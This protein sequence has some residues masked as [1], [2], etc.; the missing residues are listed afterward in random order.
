MSQ[1]DVWYHP[2]NKLISHWYHITLTLLPGWCQSDIMVMSLRYQIVDRVISERH[3]S[4]VTVMS[5]CWLRSTRCVMTAY[6]IKQKHP[7]KHKTLTIIYM[8]VEHVEC[9]AIVA[10]GGPA[11]N[12]QW[13]NHYF[14]YRYFTRVTLVLLK[15]STSPLLISLRTLNY[16]ITWNYISLPRSKNSSDWK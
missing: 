9:W 4:D 8:L 15:K 7:S 12:Q 16:S 5:N 1:N 14:R 6:N 2:V 3:H 13:I 10:D 11:F